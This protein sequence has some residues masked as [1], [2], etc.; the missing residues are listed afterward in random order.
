MRRLC[1]YLLLTAALGSPSIAAA[2]RPLSYNRDV[3]PILANHCFAC[4]GPD[5]K[6]READLRLDDRAVA[7]D[8]GAITPSA[9]DKSELIHRISSSDPEK[10]M[11]PPKAKKPLPDGDRELLRRWIAQG[12]VYEDHWAF[13]PVAD[14]RPPDVKDAAW[15]KN[16]IDRFVL[17]EL[18][19]RG[20]A[21]SLEATR[22][23]LIRRLTLDL[24]GLLPAPAEV[25]AFVDDKRPDAYEQLVDRLLQSP[26]YGER[27][28]RHWLDQARYADSN[29]YTIDSERAMWPYRDWVIKA[30]NDDMPFDQFTIEQLAGDL[31]PQPTKLQRVATAFHRNTMINEEGGTDAEQFRNEIVFDRVNTTGSVWLGLTLGCAQCHSHKFDPLSHREYYQFFAF[32]NSASDVNNRGETLEMLPGEILGRPVAEAVDNQ[33]AAA[34]RKKLEQLQKDAAAREAQ[35]QQQVAEGIAEPKW[36]PMDIDR[37]DSAGGRTLKKLDDG[38]IL[39]PREGAAKDSYECLVSAKVERIAAIRLI[40]LPHESLP[41]GGAGTASNGNFVLSE[42]EVNVDGK[43]APLAHALADHQKKDYPVIAAIDGK[44]DTGW[45]LEMNAGGQ[46]THEAW[47]I[48]A[49]PA[50]MTTGKITVKLRHEVNNHYQ[51]GRFNLYATDKPPAIHP[52]KKLWQQAVEAAKQPADQRDKTAKDVLRRTYHELD[53]EIAQ[54]MREAELTKK[55]SA[56]AATLM[57]MRELEKPRTTY[58]LTR[59]DFL[60]PDKELGALAPSTPAWLPPLATESTDASPTRLDLARWLVRPENPLTRRV[61]VNRTWMQY[62]GQGLV[63]SDND[64]G[65]QGTPPTHPELLDY[66]ATKFLEQKW[67]LKQLHR[68]IVT[69]AT[70][71]QSSKYRP[72]LKDVDPD[73]RLLA[74]QH[75]LR[76]DAETVRD[77]ALA[78]SGLLDPSLGGPTTH[79]PQPDGVYAFTQ[80]KKPWN[81]APPSE[82]YRRALYTTF[83]RSA[84]YPLFT[85]FDAPSFAAACTRRPRSNTPLQALTVANDEAFV[86]FAQALAMRVCKELPEPG[87]AADRARIQRVFVLCLAR[88]PVP[89]ELE[90]LVIY[91]RKQQMAFA[92][93]STAAKAAAP[94]ERLPALSEADAAAWSALARAILNTDEFITRE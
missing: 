1:F 35:W 62:F 7:L 66:L 76:L 80:N 69:S 33:T 10:Q 74:R 57:V 28:G 8:T 71:R 40:V 87:E 47:F 29:G 60:S 94:R 46:G 88:D 25:Q 89:R 85:T 65:L 91:L 64:F 32:F 78:A 83:I 92:A 9:P 11:P 52:D 86:E 63:E 55:N 68:L 61:A 93:D 5:A 22:T 82:R 20:L 26:H 17:S 72:E 14:A 18:E 43:P 23:T 75:R 16:D 44:P 39:A 77:V 36:V 15:V 90:A 19:Q 84:P 4:H 3:R 51:I 13:L 27:W 24:T 31:L 38:S 21:P 73:N 81:S 58:L 79:P 41:N 54:A 42:F 37:F 30:L 12:A 59:G 53:G 2:E 48:F 45:A 70:Y 67:S 6:H 50:P 49:D 34:A 56:G